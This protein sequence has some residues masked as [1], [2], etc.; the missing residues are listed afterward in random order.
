MQVLNSSHSL[1]PF[2]ESDMVRVNCTS[3]VFY[4]N[5][6]ERALECPRAE[7]T[8]KFKSSSSLWL[9]PVDGGCVTCE[10]D[11]AIMYAESAGQE[12]KMVP[13]MGQS[14]FS[15]FINDDY[16]VFRDLSCTVFTT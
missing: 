11:R 8:K 3:Q 12:Y 9:V 4:R 15:L 2:I 1:L 14:S 16:G 7:V 5:Y 10:Q 6:F 13:S